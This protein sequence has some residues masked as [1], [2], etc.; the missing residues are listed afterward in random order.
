MSNSWELVNDI[1]WVIEDI[2]GVVAER[3]GSG[4]GASY[5]NDCGELF[6]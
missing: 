2:F 4:G 1:R 5:G 3:D 6:W